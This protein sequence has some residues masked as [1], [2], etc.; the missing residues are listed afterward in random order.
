VIGAP[1]DDPLV[2]TCVIHDRINRYLRDAVPA[3]ALASTLTECRSVS[4][5]FGHVPN[6][7]F[8]SLRPTDLPG[9]G[10]LWSSNM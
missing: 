2:E 9:N 4:D 6:V 8:T 1:E 7:R 5:F 3:T 10:F